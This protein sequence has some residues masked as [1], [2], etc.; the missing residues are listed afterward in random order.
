MIISFL[1]MRKKTESRECDIIEE[2]TALPENLGKLFMDFLRLYG[3]TFNY[4]STAISIRN[5]GSYFTKNEKNWYDP[6]NPELLSLE[7][8]HNLENDVGRPAFSIQTVRYEFKDTYK[9]LSHILKEEKIADVDLKQKS[10]LALIGFAVDSS[11]RQHRRYIKKLCADQ[12]RNLEE[13]QPQSCRSKFNNGKKKAKPNEYGQNDTETSSCSS[14]VNSSEA[15]KNQCP[16][17]SSI[18]AAA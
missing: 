3:K 8:P 18:N 15:M 2:D 4:S 12:N 1:Q 11:V 13:N 16:I 17:S 7:D 6:N 5:G 10:I 14:V 9:K